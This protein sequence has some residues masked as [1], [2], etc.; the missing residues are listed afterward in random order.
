VATLLNNEVNAGV[1][2]I[3]WN[4]MDNSGTKVATGTYIYRVVAGD[5]VVSK[6]MI[7]LK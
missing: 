7:L 5:N 4:G 3:M 6:K 2:N 1:Y